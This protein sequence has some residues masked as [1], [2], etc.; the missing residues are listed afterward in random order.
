MLAILAAAIL[1]QPAVVARRAPDPA[2]AFVYQATVLKVVDGDTL[3]VTVVGWP[4][5]FTP[6]DVRVAGLD[7]PESRRPPAKA[8]CEVALGEAAKSYAKALAAPGQ[9]VRLTYVAGRNDKYRR[10]LADVTLPDGR[11]WAGVMIG[12]GYGRAYGLDHSLTK[13]AWC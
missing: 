6:I 10:L 1:A 7:T 4:D 9:T 13:S 2:R 3:R 8:A 12:A 11:D 5:P